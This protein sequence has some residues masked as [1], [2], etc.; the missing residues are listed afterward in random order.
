MKA[1]IAGYTV[2]DFVNLTMGQTRHC[3]E[4]PHT[5]PFVLPG[6]FQRFSEFHLRR[7]WQ[8]GGAEDA[9]PP[10]GTTGAP[11][12]PEVRPLGSHLSVSAMFYGRRD[13]LRGVGRL[14]PQDRGGLVRGQAIRTSRRSN[15]RLVCWRWMLPRVASSVSH[16]SG[17]SRGGGPCATKSPFGTKF[18]TPPCR[19]DRSLGAAS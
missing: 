13:L 5:K 7:S 9:S 12:S 8:T 18:H 14:G 1:R 10:E 16:T 3:R 2:L 19:V 15:E 4:L 17:K 11:E 6:F